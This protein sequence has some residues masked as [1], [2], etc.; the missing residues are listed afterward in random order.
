M[1]TLRMQHLTSL[2]RIFGTLAKEHLEAAEALKK[3]IFLDKG[4][5][6]FTETTLPVVGWQP[7][8]RELRMASLW[9]QSQERAA[10]EMTRQHTDCSS[11]YGNATKFIKSCFIYSCDKHTNTSHTGSYQ[12]NEPVNNMPKIGW[13]SSILPTKLGGANS[14]SMGT[15]NYLRC[16]SD[17]SVREKGWGSETSDNPKGSQSVCEDRTLQDGRS[18]PTPR[19]FTARELDGKNGSEGC[20]SPDPCSSKL[21]TPPQFPMRGKGLHVPMPTFWPLSSTQSVYKAAKASG[22]FPKTDGCRLIVYLNDMLML[23]QDRGQF[24]K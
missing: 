14:R 6:G 12:H 22:G 3:M 13:A 19:T 1:V 8:R 15:P 4:Q 21:P 17:T 2:G 23:H 9:Q 24:N 10:K 7:G 20:L 5:W 11:L 16:V 18:S